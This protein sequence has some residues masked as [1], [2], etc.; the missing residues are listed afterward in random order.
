[1]LERRCAVMHTD[2]T[3]LFVEHQLLRILAELP[4]GYPASPI[5][6]TLTLRDTV[7]TLRIG[8]PGD[9]DTT[10]G[11]AE[12]LS[13]AEREVL[14]VATAEINRLG[15]KVIGAEIRVAMQAAGTRWGMSTINRCLADL[16][17]KGVLLNYRNRQ[18]YG[19]PAQTTE[20]GDI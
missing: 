11:V 19:L 15:R 16:A 1:M 12:P 10:A 6:F 2:P 7:A 3:R 20:G 8:P 18:G 9:V 14:G 4:P 13:E 5:L 17:A